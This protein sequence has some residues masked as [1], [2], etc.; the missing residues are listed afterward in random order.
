[1]GNIAILIKST[2]YQRLW[3]TAQKGYAVC[4]TPITAGSG[5]GGIF[6]I[7]LCNILTVRIRT[8]LLVK[9]AEDAAARWKLFGSTILALIWELRQSD[10]K[11]KNTPAR[12]VWTYERVYRWMPGSVL[13]CLGIF[14]CHITS[15]VHDISNTVNFCQ[16]I[17]KYDTFD[18]NSC[19]TG[20]EVTEA[21]FHALSRFL[22]QQIRITISSLKKVR[23][24]SFGGILLLPHRFVKTNARLWNSKLKATPVYNCTAI[25][26][27][28]Q[29][30]QILNA[31]GKNRTEPFVSTFRDGYFLSSSARLLVLP[32]QREAWWQLH[33]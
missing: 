29:K 20:A 9:L 26:M 4:I 13:L 11:N 16:A 1:M 30:Q 31:S 23:A 33:K 6:T 22:R 27:E 8:H 15:H 10:C 28:A 25:Y 32:A 19:G 7:R 17:I 5:G 24:V 21:A 14:S 3:W 2:A 12:V 18:W